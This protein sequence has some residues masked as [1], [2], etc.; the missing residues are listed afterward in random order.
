MVVVMKSM[1]H[2]IYK[3]KADVADV[4]LVYDDDKRGF[5]EQL[6]VKYVLQYLLQTCIRD[7]HEF[8]IQFLNFC[9]RTLIKNTTVVLNANL[10]LQMK[11]I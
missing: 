5:Q 4:I 7:T 2:I 11:R 10:F 3:E 9:G 8:G 1:I 6:F